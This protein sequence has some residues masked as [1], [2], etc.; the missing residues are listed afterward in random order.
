[1]AKTKPLISVIILAFNEEKFLP[2]CLNS[3]KNQ[4][5]KNFEIII[6]DNN[7]TDRTIKIAKSFGVKVVRENKQGI[8]YAR[9]RGYSEAQSEIIARLDADS[10]APKDWLNSLYLAIYPNPDSVAVTGNLVFPEVPP[11]IQ[12]FLNLFTEIFYYGFTRLLTGHYPIVGT[13]YAIRKSAWEKISV[14]LDDKLFHEDMDLACHLNKIGKICFYREIKTVYSLRRWKR[15]FL[16]TL[17]NYSWRNV[18]TIW[19]HHPFFKR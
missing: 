12:I 3:L 9:E 18:R 11:W 7:S 5:L 6:V 15:E 10:T 14:H 8:T 13:N 17:L 16:K 2:R 4:S 19:V 1:M